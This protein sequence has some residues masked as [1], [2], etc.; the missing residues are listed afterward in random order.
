MTRSILHLYI[1][2]GVSWAVLLGYVGFL[3]KRGTLQK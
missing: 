2:Y 1:A 3:W